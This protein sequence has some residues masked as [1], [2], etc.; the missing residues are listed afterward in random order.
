ML[1]R[2][3]RAA[4]RLESSVDLNGVARDGD[5]VLAALTQQI[6]RADRDG[7]LADARRAEDRKDLQGTRLSSFS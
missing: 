3:R 7:G 5:R 2:R 6:G 1:G 4:Q